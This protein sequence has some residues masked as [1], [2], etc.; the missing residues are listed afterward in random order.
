MAP[1]PPMA[2]QAEEPICQ[3]EE[4]RL[5]YRPIRHPDLE[6]WNRKLRGLTWFA[7]EVELFEDVYDWEKMRPGAREYYS[8]IFGLFSQADE[9]VARNIGER[10]IAEIK[11][12]ELVQAYTAQGFMEQEHS[13][14]YSNI[15]FALYGEEERERILKAAAHMP[16]VRA[17]YEWVETWITS[18]APIGLRLAAFAIFEG[19][20]FQCQFLSIQLLKM[21]NIMPGI[22]ML[23][24]FIQ[25]DEAVH[26]LLACYLLTHHIRNRPSA[27]EIEKLAR[28]AHA[29]CCQF[30]DEA[31]AAARAAEG[32]PA[33]APCPV[34]HVTEAK[35][36]R[37]VESVMDA[38]CADM[39]YPQL[40]GGA[41]SPYPEAAHLTLNQMLKT[42][43][44]EHRGS[45]YSAVVVQDALRTDLG[46]CFAPGFMAPAGRDA[47]WLVAR[48][49]PAA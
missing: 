14:A 10:L 42:N 7:D 16:A 24:E 44:F 20:M 4:G 8:Y 48:C 5:T 11:T 35:M 23:N 45:T 46:R 41:A 31:C 39:G 21:Q 43:Q 25:R 3:E 36:H 34:P 22:T 28:E 30:V 18:D 2:R 38:V 12:L 19:C 13:T 6:K 32:L 17:I 37:Y 1:E 47:A 29:L 9:L 33:D 40:F 26:C 15:I 27:F 49:A